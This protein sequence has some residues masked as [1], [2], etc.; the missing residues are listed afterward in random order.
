MSSL[1]QILTFSYLSL[2]MKSTNPVFAHL[3]CTFNRHG[4]K[5]T[6]SAFFN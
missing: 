1:L 3:I 5:A 4:I 6:L 2:D